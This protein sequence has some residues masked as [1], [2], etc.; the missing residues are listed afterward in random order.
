[1]CLWGTRTDGAVRLMSPKKKL[2]SNAKYQRTSL[3]QW[4]S[5]WLPSATRTAEGLP[6]L[7]LWLEW[8]ASR[9]S[10]STVMLKCYR[11]REGKVAYNT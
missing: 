10:L 11:P 3:R 2:K 8:D 1:M 4:L 9:A 6:L 5:E 7:T